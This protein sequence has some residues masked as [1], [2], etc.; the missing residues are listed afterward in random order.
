LRATSPTQ[1]RQ[2]KAMEKMEQFVAQQQIEAAARQQGMSEMP[3][4]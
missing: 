1:E 2:T 3:I 4:Q